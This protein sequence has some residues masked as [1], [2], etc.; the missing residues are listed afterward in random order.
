MTMVR[1][2]QLL[3]IVWLGMDGVKVGHILCC[4]PIASLQECAA[5]SGDPRSQ[6]KTPEKNRVGTS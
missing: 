5:A 3:N 6:I 4:I 2:D 1:R